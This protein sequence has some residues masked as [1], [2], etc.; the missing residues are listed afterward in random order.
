MKA[1]KEIVVAI[2]AI[3]ALFLLYFGWNFLKGVNI[4]HSTN[5]YVVQFEKMNGLVPQAPVYVRGFKVGQVDEIRYDFTRT[6]SFTV[7]FSINEDIALP[8][9]GTQVNLVPDGL[10]SGEAL[11]VVFPAEPFELAYA[12]FDTLPTSIQASLIEG[13]ADALVT[14]FDP[15]LSNV[16]SLLEVF[17]A[18]L[19]ED[20]MTS[21]MR[22]VDGTMRNVN[23]LTAQLNQSVPALMDTVQNAVA[24][25]R[26]VADDVHAA[27]LPATIARADTAL[28]E[29]NILLYSMQHG[30][31]T[32]P[33]L[34]NDGALY[35]S[36]NHTVGSADS[37][38]VDLKAHPKR[39]VHFSLFGRKDR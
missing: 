5:T 8:R 14:R 3:V 29:F 35:E 38:L 37:L 33:L 31:G 2:L 12:P 19:T 15:I 20:Q 4:F 26:V 1:K 28:N 17:R 10:I 22:N 34:L 16:D 39:Y 27:N 18:T 9:T 13:M 23:H 32:L 30:D 7:T 36:V 11:E 25:I 24:Q 21:L 6:P